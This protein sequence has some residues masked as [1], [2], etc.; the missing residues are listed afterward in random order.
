MRWVTF[1]YNVITYEISAFKVHKDKETALNYF[2]STIKS[3][4]EVNTNFKANKL[5]A[6]YEY[7]F[8]KYCGISARTFKKEFDISVDEALK[9]V[10]ELESE[11]K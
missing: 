2:N 9:I 6:T 10:A 11:D 3:F 8:E 1:H 5:P 7:D 4:F